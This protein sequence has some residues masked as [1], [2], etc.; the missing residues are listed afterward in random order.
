[1]PAAKT[2]LVYCHPCPESFC[3]AVRDATI[4]ALEAAG[5]TVRVVDLYANG[6]DPVM[7]ADERRGYHT[8]ADNAVPVAEQLAAIR[9]ADTLVFVYPTWWFGLPAMLKGWLDRVWVP[10]ETFIM[11]DDD[12]RIQPAMTNISRVA[13]ITTCG[14]NWWVSKMIGEPGRKTLLRGVRAICHPRCRTL[15]LAHYEMDSSTPESRAAYLEK[16]RR[17]LSRF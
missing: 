7:D 4:A 11:P 10:H 16:V 15:Y 9:W 6:F 14:A 3:A 2:L 1:M 17:R 13:A 12:G 5:S 8:P